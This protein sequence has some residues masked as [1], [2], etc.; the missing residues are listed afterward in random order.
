MALF[1]T[2]DTDELIDSIKVRA[3]V[4]INQKTFINSDLI[5]LMNEEID[6]LM[7][8]IVLST[9]EE[10]YTR[11]DSTA[12]VSNQA[13]YEIPYRAIGSKIRHLHIEGNDGTKYDMSRIQPEHESEFQYDSYSGEER[14]Y[15]LQGDQIRIISEF[16]QPGNIVF[17]YYMKPNDLV[18][19][20]RVADI[21]DITT[22]TVT[23]TATITMG[24][25]P[26]HITINSKIDLIQHKPN[27]IILGYDITPSTVGSTSITISFSGYG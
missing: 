15:L 20:S 3:S 11:R 24:A 7:I 9:H 25:V 14:L 1:G 2:M 26:S 4:P 5:R 18:A 13:L 21:T 6:S 23:N 22:D 19:T 17:T 8:P 10:F 12:I 27:H 16:V